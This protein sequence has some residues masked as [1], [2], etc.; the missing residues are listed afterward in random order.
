MKLFDNPFFRLASRAVVVFLTALVTM[1]QATTEPTSSA[2]IQA[3]VIGA[4][5]AVVE[6]LTPVNK[7]VGVGSS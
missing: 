5:L 6:F 1:L 2:L 4:I 3:A 7:T